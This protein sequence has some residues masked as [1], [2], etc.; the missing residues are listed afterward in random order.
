MAIT[1]YEI[2]LLITAS[3]QGLPLTG[4]FFSYGIYLVQ[5]KDKK[6]Q[7]NP[8]PARLPTAFDLPGREGQLVKEVCILPTGMWFSDDKN[9]YFL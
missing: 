7:H 9:Y 6:L 8:E 2:L 3:W 1:C 4:H 5:Q